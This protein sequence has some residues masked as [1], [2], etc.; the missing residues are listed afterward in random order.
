MAELRNDN[1]LTTKMRTRFFYF[2]IIAAL[3]IIPIC[4]VDAGVVVRPQYLFI[5]APSKSGVL[6]ISNSGDQTMEVSIELKYGYHS[7]DDTGKILI[8]MP[9]Q[10]QA[11]DR[12]MV[13]WIRAY[14]S[15]FILGPSESQGVRIFA[16]PPSG[17]P[18]GEYWAKMIV[19]PKISK[20]IQQKN[21]RGPAIEMITVVTV[22]LHYRVKPVVAGIELVGIKDINRESGLV[23]TQANFKRVGNSSFWGTLQCRVLNS[24]GRV[25]GTLDRNL[26]IYKDLK[27]NLEIPTDFTGG[28]PYTLE[29]TA[30]TKRTDIRADLL[31]NAEPQ[32]WTFPI[33][34]Q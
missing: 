16:N 26:V 29:L 32:R 33:T 17:M 7:T 23:K 2:V 4:E 21:R 30:V 20:S 13:N 31:V 34:L 19:T 9:D 10:L 6:T 15:R 18:P 28:G 12:S 5:D 1:H 22:P 24:S 11:D 3:F 25:V 27:M 8:L 14:P